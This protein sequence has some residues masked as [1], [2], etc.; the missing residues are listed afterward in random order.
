M[1]LESCGLQDRVS[2][3]GS[4]TTIAQSTVAAERQLNLVDAT[5]YCGWFMKKLSVSG[6]KEC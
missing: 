1:R 3:F 2:F 6:P 5:R 4:S